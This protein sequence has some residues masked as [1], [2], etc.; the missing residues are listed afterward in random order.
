M[1]SL[2]DEVTRRFQDFKIIEPKFNL[3][4]YPITADIDTAPEELQLELID[5]Q[6]DHTV[7]EMFNAVT[8]VDFYKSLS[9]DKFPCVKKFAGKM[10]SI[11]GSTYICEQSF[12]CMKINKSQYRCSLTD[13]NLQA[14]MTISTSNFT[15][16]FKKIVKKCDRVH[17]SH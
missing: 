3:L 8:L 13:I 4:S 5:M 6:S 14:V 10:F 12:S 11:F 7:K 16:D 17:L 2:E 1:Q 15:P 9:A